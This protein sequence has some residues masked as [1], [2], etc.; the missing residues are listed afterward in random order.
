MQENNR[1][2]IEKDL[3]QIADMLLLNG[4]LN[5]RGWCM[6]RWGLL[7]SFFIMQSLQ[8]M[9]CLLITQWL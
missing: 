5:A 9:I 2:Q 3:Q 4:T 7:F 8:V 1:D 6:E